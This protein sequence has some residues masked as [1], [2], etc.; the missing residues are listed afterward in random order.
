MLR[1]TLAAALLAACLLPAAGAATMMDITKYCKNVAN[2]K[3]S[4]QAS[5]VRLINVENGVAQLLIVGFPSSFSISF[6]GIDLRPYQVRSSDFKCFNLNAGTIT[7]YNLNQL[8]ADSGTLLVKADSLT[9]KQDIV[10][11]D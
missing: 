9:L 1:Q 7:F 11:D 6:N 8:R 3:N 2:K 4:T 10:L 5:V